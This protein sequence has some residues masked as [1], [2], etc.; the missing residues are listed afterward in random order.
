V[1]HQYWDYEL[2]SAGPEDSSWR[3]QSRVHLVCSI[4]GGF[5]K[6][7]AQAL[8]AMQ[9]GPKGCPD[10]SK[11]GYEGLTLAEEF[12]FI[13]DMWVQ[14]KNRDVTPDMVRYGKRPLV[15]ALY[16]KCV[17]CG[18]EINPADL[19]HLRR[20]LRTKTRGCRV[21]SGQ[22]ELPTFEK[23]VANHPGLLALWD[24]EKNLLATGRHPKDVYAGATEVRVEKKPFWRCPNGHSFQSPTSNVK[25]RAEQGNT[26]CG[27]CSGKIPHSGNWLA[28]FPEVSKQLHPDHPGNRDRMGRQYTPE[29]LVAH[30]NKRVWW[31]CNVGPDHIWQASP[32]DRINGGRDGK[33][34]GCPYCSVPA[35]KVSVTNSL[36]QD[37]YKV[38]AAEFHPTK[39][40]ADGKV[41][42]PSDVI[43]HSNKNF[44]WMCLA[45]KGHADY[46]ASANKRLS[47]AR[48]CPRC[49]PSPVSQTENRILFELSTMFAIDPTAHQIPEW[50]GHP[51]DKFK[52]IDVIIPQ[53]RLCIEF[54]SQYW[55]G[56]R[57]E[58]G[59]D[60]DRAKAD[61]IMS[62]GW[63]VM[64][65]RE[66]ALQQLNDLDVSVA[67]TSRPKEIKRAVDVVI[68]KIQSS[69]QFE[70]TEHMR[71]SLNV[72]L[73]ERKPRKIQEADSFYRQH[74][75]Q[76][77]SDESQLEL[78]L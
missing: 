59:L 35:R 50:R 77:M 48:G 39:N 28:N 41:L 42:T 18:T 61:K 60:A 1:I 20:N 51:N 64:R 22:R 40:R 19:N 27:Y 6:T 45:G 65:V 71:D 73:A 53:L 74:Y 46:Q 21:C 23:S 7:Y 56:M 2:N 43:A 70:L 57:G 8:K 62:L 9:S 10:C 33:P 12:P 72:Y 26:A 67:L 5:S 66:G 32:N 17:S 78:E 14:S 15:G 31:V 52:N 54:D 76:N 49:S 68:R 75:L 69:A 30:S 63:K 58:A 34:T 24:T 55:H 3:P 4:H 11:Y 44:W 29:N 38:W 36:A 25:R 47:K 13:W 37:K 16:L